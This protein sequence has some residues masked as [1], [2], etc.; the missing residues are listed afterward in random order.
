MD[1]LPTNFNQYYKYFTQ[2]N[3]KM[4]TRIFIFA[5]FAFSIFAIIYV[6]Y[7]GKERFLW[8]IPICIGL[9][10]II[11]PFMFE[12]KRSLTFSHLF[13]YLAAHPKMFFELLTG[14][15]KFK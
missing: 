15:L 12:Q 4:W 14:K 1:Y 11:G 6:I 8:Y 7:S 10:S 9:F 5:G 3:S 13:W 2:E